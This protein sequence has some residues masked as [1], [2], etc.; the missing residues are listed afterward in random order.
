MSSSL[1]SRVKM[2][3]MIRKRDMLLLSLES[4][5]EMSLG[6][7]DLSLQKEVIN[8]NLTLKL[9]VY[10]MLH[11]ILC[12]SDFSLFV[13]EN[14]ESDYGTSPSCVI[15]F[16]SQ[17]IPS[18]LK[19]LS[20]P[21]FLRLYCGLLLVLLAHLQQDFLYYSQLSLII[22]SP[23]NVEGLSRAQKPKSRSLYI[24]V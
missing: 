13:E 21:F 9:S 12:C 24:S 2:R 3:T 14:H 20:T 16:F 15:I 6:N 11:M 23:R 17:K 18:A 19:V 5:L 4:A 10:L 22:S 1:W 7:R 8:F